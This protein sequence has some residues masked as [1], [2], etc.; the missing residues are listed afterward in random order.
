[1]KRILKN[2]LLLLPVLL[3]LPL[4]LLA[5]ELTDMQALILIKDM[6][7]T[8]QLTPMGFGSGIVILSALM[9]LLK[10]PKL[11]IYYDKIP[12]KYRSFIPIT[13]GGLIGLFQTIV[14]G[15]LLPLVLLQGLINGAITIGGGQQILYQ[16]L[17]GTWLGDIL[18]KIFKT[19]KK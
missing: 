1:M 4:I 10:W 6:I 14:A 2:I 15:N 17:K 13:L 12:K 16:Q 3:V 7:V 9:T 11:K 19:N 5:N 18:V 8:L